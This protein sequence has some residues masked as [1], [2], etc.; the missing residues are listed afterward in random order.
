MIDED[1]VIHDSAA[2]QLETE[3][4]RREKHVPLNGYI[5]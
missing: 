5:N 4:S 3:V 1:R 2:V